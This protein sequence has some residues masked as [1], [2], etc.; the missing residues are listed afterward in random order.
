MDREL[1]KD[2][3]KV[4]GI[5]KTVDGVKLLICSLSVDTAVGGYLDY[6]VCNCLNY[7]VVMRCENHNAF[8]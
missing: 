7:F 4:N 2:V 3:L 6:S 5:S 8:D 1:G